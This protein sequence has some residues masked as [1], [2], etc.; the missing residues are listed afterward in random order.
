M[1]R[2]PTV[3]RHS[4]SERKE[5]GKHF[6]SETKVDAIG[7]TR[8]AKRIHGDIILSWDATVS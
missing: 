8:T 2:S 5:H 4:E 3:G 1:F 6:L 7:P